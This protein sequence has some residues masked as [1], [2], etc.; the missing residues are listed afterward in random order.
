MDVTDTAADAFLVSFTVPS[1]KR[2]KI[3][4]KLNWLLEMDEDS[5]AEQ[6]RHKRHE[7]QET[8]HHADD[9]RWARL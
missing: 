6:R 2:D 3:A 1:S 7:P 8:E 9:A 5:A 4:A